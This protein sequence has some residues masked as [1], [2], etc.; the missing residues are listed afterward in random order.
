MRVDEMQATPL[1]SSW[2]KRCSYESERSRLVA[3]CTLIPTDISR[4]ARAS[5]DRRPA[6]IPVRAA[7][8]SRMQA[9]EDQ[10]V[11]EALDHHPRAA[12]ALDSALDDMAALSAEL[13]HSRRRPLLLRS[14]TS[15]NRVED[16]LLEAIIRTHPHRE[17]ALDRLLGDLA[18][19][20]G[21]ASHEND[22]EAC[23]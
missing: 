20:D 2:Q 22:F 11:E 3:I 9:V 14:A 7:D 4:P 15:L 18:G 5:V 23:A 6:V 21:D 8:A 12:A 13:Q 1:S 16:L 17:R 19:M 10:L